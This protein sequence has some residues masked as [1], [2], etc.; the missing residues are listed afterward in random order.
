MEFFITII[1]NKFRESLTLATWAISITTGLSMTDTSRKIKNQE[2]V[3]YI[4]QMESNLRVSV[5]ITHSKETEDSRPWMES[6]SKVYGKTTCL[7]RSSTRGNS[8]ELLKR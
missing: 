1:H 6:T 2:N 4:S 7:C 5:K 3:M 8:P